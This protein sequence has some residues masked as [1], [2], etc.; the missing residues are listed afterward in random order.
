MGWIPAIIFGN[1][2]QGELYSQTNHFS[3]GY[4]GKPKKSRKI[5]SNVFDRKGGANKSDPV[6]SALLTI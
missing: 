2:E 6:T 1:N 4:D 3:K 5:K